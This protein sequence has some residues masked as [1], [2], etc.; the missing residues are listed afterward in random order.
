LDNTQVTAPDIT[1][2]SKETLLPLEAPAIE[3]AREL[4]IPEEDNEPVDIMKII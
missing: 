3:A 1:R 2:G 4:F